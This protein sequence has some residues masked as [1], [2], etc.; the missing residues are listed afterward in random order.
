MKDPAFQ[1]EQME[2]RYLAH[3]EPINRLVDEL[4]TEADWMPYVAPIYGGVHARVLAI[5][6]DPGPKTQDGT[7]S[8]MLCV[9]N[10]DPSAER[11]HDLLVGAGIAVDDLVAWNAYPWYINSKPDKAQLERALPVLHRLIR[12]CP[13]LEVV[14]VHGGDA[15]RAWRMFRE[16]Y[17]QDV[18]GLRVVE[19]Y[20]TSRQ[21]L[22]HED[23]AVRQAREDKL[24]ADF[25]EVAAVLYVGRR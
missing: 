9:E 8:G 15:H 11:Y 6:R 4:R 24:A 7:G 12:V 21:A 22:R 20:H 25:A 19:T 18:R 3:V 13:R 1:R 16:R 23:P 5:L 10:D 2:S 17:P 14:M